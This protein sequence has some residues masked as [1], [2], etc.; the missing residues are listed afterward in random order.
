MPPQL[1][2]G[3]VGN[4]NQFFGVKVSQP[5]VNVNTAQDNE[6]LYQNNYATQVFYLQDGST[7]A[8]GQI[9]SALTGGTVLGQQTIDTGGNVTFEQDGSTQNWFD[10]NGKNIMRVGLLPDGTYG[11]V[12][13]QPGTNVDDAF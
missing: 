1:S 11:W 8:Y 3:P 4:Q 10:K 5:G 6:L 9:T 2:S 13:V 7:I 12:V